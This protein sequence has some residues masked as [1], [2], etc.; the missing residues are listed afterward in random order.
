MLINSN[1]MPAQ[2]QHKARCEISNISS[3]DKRIN[4]LAK[5]SL[6]NT[7]R[8]LQEMQRNLDQLR[9]MLLLQYLKKKHILS[10]DYKKLAT[11]LASIE[12]PEK[13]LLAIMAQTDLVEETSVDVEECVEFM[14]TNMLILSLLSIS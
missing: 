14:V 6:N 11:L 9:T 10:K 2:L 12:V 3:Q 13:Q 5:G 1:L 7:T 8:M 4:C